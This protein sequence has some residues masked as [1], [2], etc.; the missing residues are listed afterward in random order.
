M[1]APQTRIPTGTRRSLVI[2]EPASTPLVV[3]GEVACLVRHIG[4]TDDQSYWTLDRE[5]RTVVDG[6]TKWEG[7][8]GGRDGL[9]LRAE[10]AYQVIAT[11]PHNTATYPSTA[12][13]TWSV[14]LLAKADNP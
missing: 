8:L 4:L 12:T 13:Y 6:D 11:Q 14:V 7:W 2:R 9:T 3:P 5:P 10:G 1:R